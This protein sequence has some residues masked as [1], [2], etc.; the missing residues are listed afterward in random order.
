MKFGLSVVLYPKTNGFNFGLTCNR[1][2]SAITVITFNSNTD[3]SIN[4][5]SHYTKISMANNLPRCHLK[6]MQTLVFVEGSDEWEMLINIFSLSDFVL[7]KIPIQ[8]SRFLLEC[9]LFFSLVMIWLDLKKL[10]CNLCS[11]TS[12]H[13]IFLFLLSSVS[14][15][16]YLLF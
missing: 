11:T 4:H 7:S 2:Y 3:S 12:S 16:L 15:Q 14:L 10:F 6:L 13:L 1:F 9:Q 8:S 5:S